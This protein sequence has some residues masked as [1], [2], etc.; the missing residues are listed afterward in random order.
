MTN[1][2]G[3]D[4][5]FKAVKERIKETDEKERIQMIT[6]AIG[7]RRYRDLVDIVATIEGEDG[8]STV[9]DYL[10]K[11]QH[12]KYSSPMTLGQDKTYMEELKFR[13][14]VFELLSCRGLEP[15]SMDMSD[16]LRS[17]ENEPS[18]VDASR[19]LATRV[20]Q[21]TIEQ[22]EAGDTLFFDFSDNV[23]VSDEIEKLLHHIRSKNI[24]GISIE[25]SGSLFNI[26]PLWYCEFGRLALSNLGVKGYVIDSDTFDSV[27]SVLQ[28][29][30]AIKSRIADV[31]TIKDAKKN[32]WTRPTNRV[33]RK[34]HA[35]LIHHE[36]NN[37]KLLASR[38]SIPLLNT[39][40]DEALITY[41]DSSSTTSYRNILDC[42]NAH[43]SV[44]DVE[45][46]LVLEKFSRMKDSRIATT[47]I[48]A[49]G[50]FYNESSVISL[51]NLFC[52][53]KDEVIVKAV[54]KAIENVYK[55]CP[56]ADYVITNS[57]ETECRNRGRLKKLYRRLSKERPL[58]YQ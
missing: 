28:I 41:D 26:E 39:L 50:N 31:P 54:T 3:R 2:S 7:D 8:W 51:V 23:S 58:Y 17:L 16:L 37:L 25:Q 32:H 47:A 19:V 52:T 42:I 6:N 48:L 20:K 4:G 36:V 29:P 24:D 40:L 21:L 30:S 45:S 49:I 13:E 44:R 10:T 1:E 14:M 46:V 9:L 15:I 5:I 38:H 34:L 35:Y 27:L 33:Y 53:V 43:I 11:A 12:N 57:L 18:I 56:E 22:I 55:K